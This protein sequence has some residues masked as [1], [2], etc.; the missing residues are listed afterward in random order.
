M[1]DTRWFAFSNLYH[2]T[3]PMRGKWQEDVYT[4]D[5]EDGKYWDETGNYD[6]PAEDG[7]MWFSD[8]ACVFSSDD[9]KEVW[10]FV[11]GNR[12]MRDTLAVVTGQAE[13]GLNE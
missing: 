8:T 1:S 4:E 3:D 11:E 10:A 9:I 12:A 2:V 7:L 6:C 5:P 13:D